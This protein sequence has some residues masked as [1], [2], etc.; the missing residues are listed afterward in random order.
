MTATS[1]ITVDQFVAAPPDRV[2]RT[3][4]EPELVQRWWAPGDISDVVGHRFHLDM[5]GWGSQ[6]C[7][8]LESERYTRFV[9]TF[10]ENWT[11]TWTLAT[12]GAGT[13]LIL[14]HSGFDPADRRSLDAF[15]RMGPGW[16]DHVIPKL[17]EI[18]EGSD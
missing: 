15:T 18:A 2:W 3:L 11:L 8:V 7:E 16:R 10:T 1:T 5:P 6:P 13:R 9:Y 12:E 4:T 14:E 17:A